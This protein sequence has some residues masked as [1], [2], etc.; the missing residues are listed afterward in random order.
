[1]VGVI[2]LV[3]IIAGGIALLNL[4]LFS[5][6][7]P[8]AVPALS[9]AIS[10]Q[11]QTVTILN[12]GGDPLVNGT[13]RIL[14]DGTDVTSSISIPST[15]TVG[16]TLTYTKPG[17]IPPSI[18]MIVYTGNGANGEVLMSESFGTGPTS[19][20]PATTPTAVPGPATNFSG[21]PLSGTVP[22]NVTF[23]DLSTGFPSQWAWAFGDGNTS[24][25]KNPLH[26]YTAAG[27]YSVTLTASNAGGNNS[28]TK[29]GYITVT[30]PAPV[31]NFSGTP[32]SGTVPLNVTFT[33]LSTGSPNQWAWA[34]GDG[35]TST[36][37]NPLHTYTAAGTY[38]VTLTASNAGGN[39]SVTKTG[40][41]TVT[42]PAPVANF[43][44]T[45]ISGTA[46]LGIQFNDT[47]SGT[48]TSWA[49]VFGDGGTSTLQNP[50]HTYSTT[51]TYSVT[52]TASNAGGNNSITKTGYITV[53]IPVSGTVTLNSPYKG[54]Y[55]ESGSVMQF[56]NTWPYTS[57]ITLNGVTINLNTGDTVKLV[58][59]SNES[60]SMYSTS[61]AFTVFSF[62]DILVYINNNYQGRGAV[63]SISVNA[64][65]Q[66]QSTV[67]LNMP[68][69]PASS[70][71]WTEFEINNNPV[72]PVGS[73]SAGVRLIG[74]NVPFNS[75]PGIT[76]SQI[77]YVGGA[78][79]YI[80]M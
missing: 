41:I 35:N 18:V 73:S 13:Y 27:T 60:G 3:V 4:I 59:G 72:F 38:S 40:Y 14:V 76:S 65:D 52:L 9:A 56:R 45:P 17:T 57:S 77:Y 33:D 75:N 68:A 36:I 5:Q 32:L 7:Q 34:F 22:L 66:F 37:K 20:I 43:T 44:A 25:I 15:W 51:G 6:P 21:T 49:W 67:N 47:S 80:T 74:L 61:S 50:T 8:Q 69:V 39:N 42:A 28:V 26:T 62:N 11:S 31:A 70:A 30:V 1:M 63:S 58:W 46:P 16:E 71:A 78:S 48:P 54:G 10:N 29:T 64:F 24:T 19:T 23:T 53:T 55:I 2:I 79:A 12:N